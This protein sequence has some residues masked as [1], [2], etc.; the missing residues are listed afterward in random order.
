VEKEMFGV[1]LSK[2]LKQL[3]VLYCSKLYQKAI[4]ALSF[5]MSFAEAALSVRGA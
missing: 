5:V 2:E 1:K 4:A 3:L